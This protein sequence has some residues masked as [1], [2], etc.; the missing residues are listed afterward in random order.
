MDQP[1]CIQSLADELLSEILDTLLEPAPHTLDGKSYING[2][3]SNAE[4]H[5]PVGYGET[6]D[7]DR[8]RLV[9]KRFMRIGTPR[10]F[11]RFNLRFSKDGFRRLGELL[12]MQRACYVKTV[13][14]LVRPFYQGSGWTPIFQKLGTSNPSL[15][16]VHSRRLHEQV[17]LIETN[18]D[19]IQLRLGI[20][21]F[22][23]LQ[24]IKLLRLQDQD[25]ERLLDF[26]RDRSFRNTESTDP[27]IARFEWESACSRAV[28]TLGIALLGSQCTAIRFIGPQ[29]SPEATLQLL[30]APSTTLAAMGSRLTSL[31]INFHSNTDI[32][33]TM[34]DLSSVFHR[35]FVEAKNLVSIH[36]GFPPKTPLDLDLEAIFHDIRWKTLRTLSL[37]GWRLSADEIIS[38]ARRHRRQLRDF[39]LCAVYLRPMGRWKDVLAV[40]REEMERLDRVELYDIDY[41]DHFDA[42]SMTSG[43]EVFDADLPAPAPSSLS[44]AAITS[45]PEEPP[46]G[47]G[48]ASGSSYFS[49]PTHER[50][51][52]LSRA[53]LE[54]LR[55]LSTDD[56]ED[57]GYIVQRDQVPLW[58]AW[59]L[60]AQQRRMHT[61][62]HGNGHW[63]AY[64]I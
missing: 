48:P 19:L 23:A 9:C 36:I 64:H 56:L 55:C 8:F 32:T 28:T 10:K 26:I 12:D 6:S 22:S 29:I 46:W 62:G 11:A 63:N 42:L 57:N 33:P 44:V 35:F 2:K 50:R 54:N 30:K 38:L 58:A 14:Y 24:E 51:V 17:T 25:D 18:Q 1:R 4:Q 16:Q 43:I 47:P 45:F 49:P 60:S 61:N 27:S 20:A 52:P 34:S 5:K 41:A 13:T 59:V 31:D 53:S 7:L 3:H 15:A 37:Q 21:A 39:R 40:L